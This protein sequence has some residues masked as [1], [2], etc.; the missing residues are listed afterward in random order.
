[1]NEVAYW[2]TGISYKVFKP[3]GRWKLTTSPEWKGH[4]MYVEHDDGDF[5]L[6]INE[7]S[8]VFGVPK[9]EF[10]FAPNSE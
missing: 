1:M 7:N 8:I 5:P 6:W 9:T 10:I 3:T 4:R 2:K